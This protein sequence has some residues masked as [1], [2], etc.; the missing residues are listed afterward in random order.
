M[1]NKRNYYFKS[2][3]FLIND[4]KPKNI[5]DFTTLFDFDKEYEIFLTGKYFTGLIFKNKTVIRYKED[6][7]KEINS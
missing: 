3:K 6:F 1:H 7:I 5:F 2:C 4:K